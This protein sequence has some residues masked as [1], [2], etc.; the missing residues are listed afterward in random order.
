MQIPEIGPEA[1]LGIEINAYAA[2]LARVTIW[3]GEI[4][5]MLNNGFAYLRN[6]ILRP[7]KSIECRDALLDWT[8]PEHVKEASWPPAD[9]IVGNPPFLGGKQLRSNLGNEYVDA[10][11]RVYHDRVPQE[12][13]FVTY[14]HEKARAMVEA[15]QI[16]R[17][18]LLATQGIRGGA[19]RRVL[20]RIAKT[21]AI[22]LA[23]SS[24]PWILNGAN[25][26]VS[27][28]CYDNGTEQTRELNGLFVSSINSDLT[29]GVDLTQA[30]RLTE[31]LGIAYM[32]DT[33]GGAFDVPEWVALKWLKLPNPNGRSNRDVLK[34]WVNGL[35]LTRRP[36]NYLSTAESA[37]VRTYSGPV[38]LPY[39]A[40]LQAGFSG[41]RPL[42]A[43]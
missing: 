6:P 20:E 30:R 24:E 39:S 41:G 22:F 12:A 15:G 3:I 23:W 28:L 29:A 32:G 21:G 1:V 33:K 27:F 35:D 36:R 14:W 26:N 7:L 19:N 37:G 31:N 13:D 42:T 5:W 2:E 38:A 18:G 34:P 16:G 9:V 11:F 10:L 40:H 4:Q 43:G 17:V 25:V 8:D